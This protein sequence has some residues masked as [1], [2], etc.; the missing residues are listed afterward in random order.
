MQIILK[1]R[2]IEL[3]LK[4]Y[5][6]SQGIA[7]AGR[8]FLVDFT[9]GR[10]E[11]GVSATIDIGSAEEI[12]NSIVASVNT[13]A[14]DTLMEVSS[15][16]IVETSFGK[17]EELVEVPQP[18]QAKSDNEERMISLESASTQLVQTTEEVPV[19]VGE[20]YD[21]ELKTDTNSP[22]F[23]TD[24]ANKTSI[25]VFIEKP[26]TVDAVVEK[27]EEHEVQEQPVVERKPIS[28]FS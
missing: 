21:S 7:L 18:I 10:K 9:A 4:M 12:A 3:A 25:N 15:Q 5:L 13:P 8:S 28:L 19:T 16:G 24:T 26:S 22:P 1:Q 20:K 2:D 14:H 17:I 27:K 11:S 6:A 23:I